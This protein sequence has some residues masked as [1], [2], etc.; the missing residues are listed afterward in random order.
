MHKFNVDSDY[1]LVMKAQCNFAIGIQNH[2][3]IDDFTQQKLPL[4]GA[5]R[6][7]IRPGLGVIIPFQADRSPVM[8]FGI[9]FHD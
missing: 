5:D 6:D 9:E 3:F 2:G 8:F 1:F 7:E 4:V